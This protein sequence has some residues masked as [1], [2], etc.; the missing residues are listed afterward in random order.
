MTIL[1]GAHDYYTLWNWQVWW[2]MH[3]KKCFTK[4]IIEMPADHFNKCDI[5]FGSSWG[6]WFFWSVLI[7]CQSHGSSF[8]KVARMFYSCIDEIMQLYEG[9]M[10]TFCVENWR[11]YSWFIGARQYH[12]KNIMKIAP[13]YF[14]AS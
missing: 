8:S 11:C 3:N 14:S 5:G 13:W 6:F 10:T 2:I 4:N 7:I 9:L 12:L 1:F